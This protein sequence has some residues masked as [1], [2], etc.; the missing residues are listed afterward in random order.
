MTLHTIQCRKRDFCCFWLK[1]A[2]NRH[3]T[4][5]LTSSLF[6]FMSNVR[7]IGSDPDMEY[8]NQRN[9]KNYD[10]RGEYDTHAYHSD[11][12]FSE[13]KHNDREAFDTNGTMLTD[14]YFI[15]FVL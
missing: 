12:K 14:A 10:S 1:Y 8:K 5:F 13:I 2:K 7:Q 4:S 9:K 11:E 6:V 15:F 3:L